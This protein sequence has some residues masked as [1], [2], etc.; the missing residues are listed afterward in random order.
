ML[1]ELA[2]RAALAGRAALAARLGTPARAELAARAELV[3]RA[4]LAAR[5]GKPAQ[6]ELAA[7]PGRPAQPVGRPMV[8]RRMPPMEL[9]TPGKQTAARPTPRTAR[10]TPPA[11]TCPV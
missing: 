3:A 4:E 8:P 11:W 1:A 7:R 10:W 6:A 5:P 9:S 2:V